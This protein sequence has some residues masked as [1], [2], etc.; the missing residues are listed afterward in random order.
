VVPPVLEVVAPVPPVLPVPGVPDVHPFARHAAEKTA[1]SKIVDRRDSEGSLYA[2]T[3]F[4]FFEFRDTIDIVQWPGVSTKLNM[5]V[6]STLGVGFKG[7]C[8][9]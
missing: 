4:P 1:A 5:M 7:K 9:P 3:S 2:I 8:L 6:C